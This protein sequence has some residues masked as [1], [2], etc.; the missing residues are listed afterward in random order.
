MAPSG[1][2]AVN[3]AQSVFDLAGAGAQLAAMLTGAFLASAGG[4]FVAWLLDRM[5]RKRQERSIALVCV[6]LM[7][8]LAVILNLAKGSVGRGEPFGPLTMRFISRAQ[9]DLDVYERNR[10][11][12]ADI[13]DSELR[14][15]I[16]QCMARYMLGV[17]GI[18]SETEM[19]ERLDG[20]MAEARKMGDTAKLEELS[21][22]RAEREA[23]RAA[24]FEFL[25]DTVAVA[26]P[27]S[28]KL[29]SV[30]KSRAGDLAGLIA[31]NSAPAATP[32]G[33]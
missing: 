3:V 24:S 11:R 15:E 18:L 13:D 12:I 5:Q 20:V 33:E 25:M 7:M 2:V 4:F 8:G 32:P 16:Y 14:A 31:R 19:L 29:R 17:E 21:R 10:E 1:D 27:V 6:D 28:A 30:A 22:Q 23:R 26:Q 9:R